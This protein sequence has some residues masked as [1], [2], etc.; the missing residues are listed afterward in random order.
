MKKFVLW[1]LIVFTACTNIF[2][3]NPHDWR[4][5]STEHFVFI[6]QE[7]DKDAA[8]ELAECCEEVYADVTVFFDSYPGNIRC[9]V[10]GDVD[11]ANGFF[12][13]LPVHLE[14]YVRSPV[15]PWLGARS[16][17]WLRMLL[18][19]EFT[20]FVDL[21]SDRGLFYFLSIF[22]GE[23]FKSA[24]AAF[25]PFWLVEGIAVNLETDFSTGGRGRNPFFE[26]QARAML[27]ENKQ[28]NLGQLEYDSAYPPFGRYYLFGYYL[29]NY[30]RRHYG[31][32]IYTRVR[33]RFLSF[34][35]AGPW[36][37]LAAETGKHQDLILDE[38]YDE[39][40]IRWKS[41]FELP[42]GRLVSKDT[43]GDYFL[44]VSTDHGLIGYRELQS[45]AGAFVRFDSEL[46]PEEILFEASLYDQTSFSANKEGNILV[47]ASLVQDG[48]D[49]DARVYSELYIAEID[50]SADMDAAHAR[51]VRLRRLT[52]GTRLWH[53]AI[54]QDGKQLFAVQS[55]GSYSRLVKVDLSSGSV[56]PV[57]EMDRTDVFHPVFSPD[58]K[59]LAFE[60]NIRG[61][62]DIW[63][64]NVE[65]IPKA[66]FNIKSESLPLPPGLQIA[67]GPDE[68]G[69]HN[70][71]FIDNASLLFISDRESDNGSDN[72]GSLSAYMISLENRRMVCVFKDPV[73]VRAAMI[74]RDGLLY[75]SNV[76]SGVCVL[77][78][79]PGLLSQ[80]KIA[81]AGMQQ[82]RS[83]DSVPFITDSRPFF[84]LPV[85]QFWMPDADYFFGPDETLS[86]WFGA[87]LYAESLLGSNSWQLSAGIYPKEMQPV[88]SFSSGL[89]VGPF[90]FYLGVSHGFTWV[91]GS[92][93]FYD[94]RLSEYLLLSIPLLEHGEHNTFDYIEAYTG[95]RH[96]FIMQ[97]EQ[98]F[99]FFNNM[100][101]S[102]IAYGN[103]MD[104][105]GGVWCN[106]L[107]NAGWAEMYPVWDWKIGVEYSYP[108][109]V[110]PGT[111]E[112]ILLTGQGV[113]SL[114]GFFD[115]SAIRLGIESSWVT[116]SFVGSNYITPRGMFVHEGLSRNGRILGA[117]D[118][119]FTLATLDFTPGAGL[120]LNGIG[121]GLHAEMLAEWDMEPPRFEPDQEV[122]AGLEFTFYSGIGVITIP[123]GIGI[124]AR[125]SLVDAAS[126]DITQDLR[127]YFF[128][129]FDS[130]LSAEGPGAKTP[131]KAPRRIQP[132]LRLEH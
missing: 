84:Y 101:L 61:M 29:V 121:M 100:E 46:S 2:A 48:I 14:L 86:I 104:L 28:L 16:S 129:S 65:S 64:L 128:M 78:A 97:D 60:I 75:S 96:S 19:H 9:V 6:Y 32:D 92:P 132:L 113:I 73:G 102:E 69:D 77:F 1:V 122:F 50:Y 53:P 123:L 5:I 26:M 66:G 31:A 115:L 131:V 112:G 51:G 21:V 124:A 70:P 35:L 85:F 59:K 10:R 88:I 44:P 24:S 41:D 116:D 71:R 52:T 36:A 72:T 119:C 83:A 55:A 45:K 20:H 43:A 39:L 7:K 130:F 38:M 68:Y 63:T 110:F 81:A 82:Y 125:I 117:I 12:T 93:G 98:V 118:F 126:F 56:N 58:G 95:I 91:D 76:S 42:R 49:A 47:F 34:P 3:Q 103:R 74:F 18:T 67:T 25:W 80:V 106:H 54:S 108:L 30:L 114:P 105:W 33:E 57:F 94:E 27:F 62:Q 13:P 17:N 109:P 89:D 11:Y 4:E 15:G 111:D 120:H 79:E 127:P 37:A 99:R 90:D 22:M 87:Q 107:H 8:A 23:S 40:K